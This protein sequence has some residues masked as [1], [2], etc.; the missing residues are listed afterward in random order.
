MDMKT[1]CITVKQ[2]EQV[3][4]KFVTLGYGSAAAST[5]TTFTAKAQEDVV[6]KF[7]LLTAD[8]DGLI[9]DIRIGNQSLNCSD[10]DIEFKAL[11]YSTKRR[12]LIGVAV[13]GNIQIAIDVTMDDAAVFGGGFSCEAID[14]APSLS[15]Q[16]PQL[17]RFFGLG[18]V[19]VPASGSATLSAQALRGCTLR[20]LI[21]HAHGASSGIVVEDITVKGRSIFSGQASDGVA[22]DV[23]STDTTANFVTLNTPIQTNERVQVQLKNTTIAAVVV[24]GACYVD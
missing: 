2:S 4:P 19:S 12:P 16:A 7:A 17:N 10:S 18:S 3:N 6:L 8:K 1:N 21:L 23:L 20:D 15:A 24:G 22:L 11:E 9:N 14:K 13:D 5:K